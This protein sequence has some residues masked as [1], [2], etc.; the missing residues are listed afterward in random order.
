MTLRLPTIVL[1]A[2]AVAACGG[3][4]AA[5][6]QPAP[7]AADS[8]YLVPPGLGQL[9]QDAITLALRSDGIELRFTPLD[10]RVIRLLSPDAYASIRVLLDRNA[11]TIDSVERRN[12]IRTPGLVMVAFYGLAPNSRFDPQLVTVTAHDRQSQP[13]AVIPLSAAF[14]AQQLGVRESALGLFV[15]EDPIPVIEPFTVSYLDASTDDWSRRLQRFDRERGRI[16]ARG[17][18]GGED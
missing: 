3:Q 16:K 10:E 13:V 2:L 14:S 12:G 18:T 4:R 5:A 15:F 9:R 7:V 1:L 17:G 11:A 6:Q 8:S